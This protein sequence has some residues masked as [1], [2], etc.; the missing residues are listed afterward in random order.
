MEAIADMLAF[1]SRDWSEDT[2]DAWLWGIVHGWG[3]GDE[4]DVW[5]DV[6]R[7]HGW[8]AE[9]VARLQRL[10]SSWERIAYLVDPK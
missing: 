8:D 9:T 1:N 7:A 10:H 4:D 6:A 5:D 3:D 2:A